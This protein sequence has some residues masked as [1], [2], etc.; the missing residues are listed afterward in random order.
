MDNTVTLALIGLGVAVIGGLPATLTALAALRQGRVNEAKTDSVKSD[1]ADN[2]KK[3][4]VLVAKTDAIH[5]LAN[6]NLSRLASELKLANEKIVGMERLVTTLAKSNEQ[7]IAA[8]LPGPVGPA[9][10][11]GPQ[12]EVGPQGETGP[13]GKLF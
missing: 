11:T 3:T 2:T 9:G 10:E 6:G 7:A 13:K 12:G 5:D 8:T 4:E 1:V